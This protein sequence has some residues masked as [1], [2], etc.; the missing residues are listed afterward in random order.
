MLLFGES[1]DM[2]SPTRAGVLGI[3]RTIF[4]SSPNTFSIKALLIPAAI[5]T[6]ILFSVK[7]FFISSKTPPYTF[8]FTARKIISDFL[9]SS[10]NVSSL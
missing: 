7:S 9:T 1:A 5:E 8:G 6:K 3:D 2:P 10:F 4:L